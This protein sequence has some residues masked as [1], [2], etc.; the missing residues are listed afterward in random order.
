MGIDLR[1]FF[2]ATNPGNTLFA[3]PCEDDRKYYIDFSSVRGGQIVQDLQD[4]IALWSPEEPT[5]QLFT[6]HI[7]CG[8]STELLRLKAALE[9]DDF[10]VVYF[11]SSK[12]LELSD[13]DVGDILLAIARRVSQS[14][15]ALQLEKPTQL[16]NLLQG[17]ARLL[18]AEIELSACAK[19]P[20]G[21]ITANSNGEFSLD[22]GIAK[23]AAK[24][25]ASPTLRDKLRGYLEPRTN[26]ILD[27]INAELIEPGIAKLKLCGKHGLVVIVDNLD[28]VD[29]S[30]KPWGRPQQE[31][32]FVDR[33][34]QLRGLKC[35]LV[36]TMPL[37][38][39]FSSDFTNLT[40]RFAVNPQVLPMVPIQLR[41]GSECEQGMYLL[42]QMVLAR[43]F[44]DSDEGERLKRIPEI[45]DVPETLNLLC[46]ISGGHVRNL[47]R[48]L[49]D[50][51]KRQ[52]GLPITRS[53]LESVIREYRH[54]RVLAVTDTEWNLLRQV[55]QEKK[56][57]GEEGYQTLIRS[58][59][60]Y[61]YRYE[62]DS[63]FDVDPIL[64][65]AK[66][67]RS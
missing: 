53:S 18:Q 4:R 43:A 5:C 63:W 7:G 42:R 49:N 2:Q 44:P 50:S 64:A 32:L 31:Y 38:L 54:N 3:K 15:E 24:A 6:G 29:S 37:A 20:V 60:V 16:H 13:V 34:E 66:E 1:K 59:F 58:L 52:R 26:G 22:L 56:V 35:H 61:E 45:F 46:R 55:A 40:H 48:L 57:A 28:R 9:Q 62:E 39:R 36:Y 25:K 23:I 17:A 19:T 14:L 12:D 41:D 47:L 27:A 65:D 11:E 8:K 10:H 21:Q 51:I 67:L 33:G 30:P